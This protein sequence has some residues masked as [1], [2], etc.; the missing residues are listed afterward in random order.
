MV[1]KERVV[2]H[3]NGCMDRKNAGVYIGR[4]AGTLARW[5]T[6]GTGP[7]YIKRGRVWYRKEDLDAWLADG[8]VS[9]AA[10]ARALGV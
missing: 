6:E 7:K 10:Q 4:S 8:E 9:S 2:I 3:P 1:I 5:A